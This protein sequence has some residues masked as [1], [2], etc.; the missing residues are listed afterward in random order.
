M[1]ITVWMDDWYSRRIYLGDEVVP[2]E[3]AGLSI[4]RNSP[5]IAADPRR[6]L[7]DYQNPQ[8]YI[9]L[10]RKDRGIT[11]RFKVTYIPYKRRSISDVIS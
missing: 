5:F 6:G 2:E 11:P 10:L 7:S 8:N 1:R 3:L 9:P 4:C